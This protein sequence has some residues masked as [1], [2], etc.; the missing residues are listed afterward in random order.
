MLHKLLGLKFL[1]FSIGSTLGMRVIKVWLIS[2]TFYGF[3]KNIKNH[4]A[5]GLTNEIPLTLEE[6]HL[7][8]VTTRGFEGIH[9]ANNIINVAPGHIAVQRSLIILR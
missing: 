4:G 2:L 1:M 8:P 3:L 5:K 9:V 6:A 7:K